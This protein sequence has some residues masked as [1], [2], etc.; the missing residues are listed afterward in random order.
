M[1]AILQT[2]VNN[3]IRIINSAI[4]DACE[5]GDSCVRTE[6]PYTG[7]KTCKAIR[8][9]FENEGWHVT[10]ESR[11]DFV[12]SGDRDDPMRLEKVASIYTLTWK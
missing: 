7:K 3:A 9:Y 10:K 1:T 5:N 4:T 6:V 11:M 8:E 12:G 2:D